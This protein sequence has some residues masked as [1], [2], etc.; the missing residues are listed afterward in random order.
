MA[1]L[2]PAGIRAV[3]EGVDKYVGDMNRMGG[4]TAEMGSR[5]SRMAEIAGGMIAANVFGRLADAFMDVARGAS[6]LVKESVLTAAR[7]EELDAVLLTIGR[8][9]GIP[10]ER[11]DELVE[12]IKDLGIT[13]DVAQNLLIQFSRYQL[14]MADTTELAR[15]AQDAAVISMQDSSEAL[16]GLMHGIVTM[17]TRVLRTYGITLASVTDAQEKYA[18]EIGKTRDELS[19]TEMIQAVLNA[20]LAQGEQIAG[21]YEAAMETAGKQMRSMNRYVM[22][23]KSNIGKPFLGAFT[24]VIKAA[25]SWLKYFRELTEEGAILNR[26]LTAIAS[27]VSRVLVKAFDRMGDVF[28]FVM[29]HVEN[30]WQAIEA[31]YGVWGQLRMVFELFMNRTKPLHQEI[32]PRLIELFQRYLLPVIEKVMKAFTFWTRAIALGQGPVHA[33]IEALSVLVPKELVP[34]I[35]K[36]HEKWDGFVSSIREFLDKYKD[37]IIAALKAIGLAITV[38]IVSRKVL[39]AIKALSLVLGLLTSPISLLLAVIGTLGIAWAKNWGGIRDKLTDFW[40]TVKPIFENISALGKYFLIIIEDGDYLNDWITHLPE[41]WQGPIQKAG[42]IL[43][44]IMDAGRYFLFVIKEGDT[45][46]D[47]LTHLPEKW[48]APIQKAGEVLAGIQDIARKTFTIVISYIDSFI[49]AIR[50]GQSP[51]QAFLMQLEGFIPTYIVERIGEIIEAIKHLFKTVVE[52]VASFI[53]AIQAGQ[54]PLQAFLMQLEGFIPTHIVEKIGNIIRSVLGGILGF[55]EKI[56]AWFTENWPVIQAVFLT[57]WEVIKANVQAAIE[58][59]RPHIEGLIESL[60]SLFTPERMQMF[61]NIIAGVATAVGAILQALFGIVVGIIGGVADAISTLIQVFLGVV[62]SISG[63]IDGFKMILEG[64]LLGGIIQ[65]FKNIVVGISAIIMGLHE[66]MISL[67]SG[68]VTT[69]INFFID[70]YNRLVGK[71]LVNDIVEGIIAAF[72]GLATSMFQIGKDI[73]TGLWDGLKDVWES[74][75]E[76]FTTAIE[77]VVSGIAALLGLDSPSR[78]FE[79]IG[80]DMMAGLAKGIQ[81]GAQLPTMAAQVALSQQVMPAVAG[82]TRNQ[83]FNLNVSTSAPSEPIIADFQ[84]LALLAEMI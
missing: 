12:S 5:L 70:L 15:L 16:D 42:E 80:Q 72:V 44:G 75:K 7:V 55:A 28:D 65:I 39:G 34:S 14:D 33:M 84:M 46:N 23:L 9:A 60:R 63:I 45:L 18:K 68:I 41:K 47:W 36:L 20:V 53:K 54:S 25:T 81:T 67:I 78:L 35:L 22:E 50:G 61:G 71:S 38:Y 66:V 32:L 76:W 21:A 37:E 30:L 77:D 62:E 19:E 64:D 48:Q 8:N 52:Y 79:N 56:K 4:A 58:V 1:A 57:A 3:A 2:Q 59:L 69:V 11:L 83:E 73:I 51:L 43:A 74:V 82:V 49:R 13:T 6:E 27:F 40:N 17:N 29:A 31:G 10:K 24:A 26:I